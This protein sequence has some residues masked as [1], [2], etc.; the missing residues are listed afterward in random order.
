MRLS[1]RKASPYPD[2]RN[3]PLTMGSK[4][5]SRSPS[6]T[7]NSIKFTML[8]NLFTRK[9]DNSTTQSKKKKREFLN[10]LKPLIEQKNSPNTN[11]QQQIQ[12]DTNQIKNL[13]SLQKIATPAA[14]MADS[15]THPPKA[16]TSFN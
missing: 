9:Q 15:M 3:L 4:Q 6:E 2:G 1:Q 16:V 5:Q 7:N 8:S 10:F 11:A 12:F 13:S 14:A